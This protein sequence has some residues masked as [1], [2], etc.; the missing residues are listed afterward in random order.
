MCV[1]VERTNSFESGELRF[2]DGLQAQFGRARSQFR[3]AMRAAISSP[4]SSW[5][6]HSSNPGGL[7]SAIWEAIDIVPASSMAQLPTRG[8]VFFERNI[9]M[10]SMLGH[11]PF[12]RISVPP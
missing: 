10:L 7:R 2:N 4:A 9:L 6:I 8:C 12:V 11:Q 5:R 3:A 1:D